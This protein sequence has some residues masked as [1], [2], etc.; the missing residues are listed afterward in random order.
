M[1]EPMHCVHTEKH[2]YVEPRVLDGVALDHVVFVGPVEPGIAGAAFARGVDRVVGAAGQ[3]RANVLVDEEGL[4]ACR[5]G[6]AEVAGVAVGAVRIGDVV[7]QLLVHLTDFLGQRHRIEERSDT[8]FSGFARLQPR[9]RRRGGAALAGECWQ[10][11]THG[12][13]NRGGGNQ[14]LSSPRG[15]ATRIC[16]MKKANLARHLYPPEST[17]A[18]RG[19]PTVPRP[20]STCGESGLSKLKLRLAVK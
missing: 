19:D 15:P 7:N 14:D 8:S 4:H 9:C 3:Y 2:W 20:L 10:T 11:E 13:D 17:A 1:A 18:W 5:V 16:T 6:H 12:A